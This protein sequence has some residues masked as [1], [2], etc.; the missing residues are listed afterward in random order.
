MVRACETILAGYFT[1]SRIVAVC[2]MENASFKGITVGQ[3]CI[4]LNCKVMGWLNQLVLLDDS[5]IKKMMVM[6]IK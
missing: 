4:S 2:Y 5:F 6:Q 1:P 3:D